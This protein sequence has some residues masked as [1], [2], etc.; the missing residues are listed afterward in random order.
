MSDLDLADFEN[1]LGLIIIQGIKMIENLNPVESYQFLQNNNHAVLIDV[2][3]KMEHAFVGRPLGAIHIAWK[4]FP[5]WQV[6]LNFINQVNEVVPNRST[7]ILL[8]CRSGQ[9][10]LDAARVLEQAGYQHLINITE[11]F[12]GALDTNNQ[13][14]HINGWRFHQLPW[15]QS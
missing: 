13:R 7:P 9:R 14:G 8:L 3:T 6:N 2:R 5:D 12:E 11:G 4:E 1:R 10:S 15:E